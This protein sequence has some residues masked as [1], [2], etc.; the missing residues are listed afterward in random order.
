MICPQCSSRECS[1]WACRFSGIQHRK[2]NGAQESG[3]VSKSET[4]QGGV[5]PQ[6]ARAGSIPARTP[7][8]YFLS[9][10]CGEE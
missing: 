3:D 4:P 7:P 6:M 9:A 2:I 8:F 5:G 1:A 10:E